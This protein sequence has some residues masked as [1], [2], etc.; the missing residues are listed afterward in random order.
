MPGCFYLGP[1]P[2]LEV[3]MPP[4]YETASIDP[5]E[6]IGVPAFGATVWVMYS[7]PDAD[8]LSFWWSLQFDGPIGDAQ[9]FETETGEGS[10][11]RLVHDDQLD[12]QLLRCFIDDGE[13]DTV[14]IDWPVDLL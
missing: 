10:Q 8:A 2:T 6:T 3:N 7:D 4:E 5:G 1:L 11:I 14:I 13:T 12:G 9:P